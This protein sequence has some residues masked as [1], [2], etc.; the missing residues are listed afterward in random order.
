M[1]LET[2]VTSIV[3]RRLGCKAANSW[4]IG[5]STKKR[6]AA[7][8]RRQLARCKILLEHNPILILQLCNM[9][10]ENTKLRADIKEANN[11]ALAAETD[12][13]L[14]QNII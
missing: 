1:R 2:T 8:N 3:G 10:V 12:K 5:H 14:T 13:L 4:Y 11:S 7:E 9:C 6:L